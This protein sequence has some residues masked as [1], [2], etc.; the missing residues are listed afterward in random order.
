M[1]RRI[2]VA[3]KHHLIDHFNRKRYYEYHS[4]YRPVP[5]EHEQYIRQAAQRYGWPHLLDSTTTRRIT[6]GKLPYEKSPEDIVSSRLFFK[7]DGG[8]LLSRIALQYHRRR[9]A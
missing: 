6:C 2:E 8:F 7:K 5:P 4:G 3:L 9:W 1:P